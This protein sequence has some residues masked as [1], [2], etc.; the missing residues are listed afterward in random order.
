MT[1]FD[2]Y[3]ILKRV[4]AITITT[5]LKGLFLSWWKSRI[6]NIHVF[7][8]TTHYR[9]TYYKACSSSKS[10]YTFATLEDTSNIVI[11]GL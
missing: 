2:N 5:K 1:Y 11:I 8:S 7:A 9:M 10:R 3:L 6:W 4:M